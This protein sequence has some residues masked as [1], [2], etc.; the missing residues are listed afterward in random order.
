MTWRR[1][2]VGLADQAVE[3]VV[4]VGIDA[5]ARVGDG[6]QVVVLLVAK[7]RRLAGGADVAQ[8]AAEFVERLRLLERDGRA[9]GGLDVGRGD[10][11]HRGRRCS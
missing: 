2:L 3:A 4:G 9:V 8:Q 1:L 7:G 10:A 6:L 11:A 5:R